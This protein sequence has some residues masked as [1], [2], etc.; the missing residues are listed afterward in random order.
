[1]QFTTVSFLLFAAVTLLCY[2]IMPQKERWKL[3]LA[4][5]WFFYLWAGVEYAVFILLTTVTTYGCTALM[6]GNLQKQDT[7]LAQHKQELSREEKKAY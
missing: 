3:L 5:S 6:A 1:M 4:A 7:Y 2:Y